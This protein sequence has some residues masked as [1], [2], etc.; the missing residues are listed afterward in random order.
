M[1]TIWQISV[2]ETMDG[3]GPSKVLFAVDDLKKLAG[4]LTKRHPGSGV[5]A[6][7][8]EKTYLTLGY[9]S[10]TFTKM[11]LVDEDDLASAEKAR[12][13]VRELEERMKELQEQLASQKA[14]VL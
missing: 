13:N 14:L 10:Y 6:N 12:A 3:R 4:W 7:F 9:S 8:H 11:S 2:N 1:K 5:A